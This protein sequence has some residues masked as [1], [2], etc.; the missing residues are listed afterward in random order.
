MGTLFFCF[1]SHKLYNKSYFK[2]KPDAKRTLL[3]NLFSR[4]GML[5]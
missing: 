1:Y 2:D 5:R 4:W 3:D